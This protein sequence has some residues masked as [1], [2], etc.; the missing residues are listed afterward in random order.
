MSA[1]RFFYL[2]SKFTLVDEILGFVYWALALYGLYKIFSLTSNAGFGPVLLVILALGYALL[3]TLVYIYGLRRLTNF[4][5][6][7]PTDTDRG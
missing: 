3:I 4:F 5:K 7:E 1:K 2:L 6:G